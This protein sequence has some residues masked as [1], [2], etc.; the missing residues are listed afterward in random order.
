MKKKRTRIIR[1]NCMWVCTVCL[2]P[3]FV[4]IYIIL[5]YKEEDLYIKSFKRINISTS[6]T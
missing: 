3:F 1:N 6:N 5:F 2:K 4:H